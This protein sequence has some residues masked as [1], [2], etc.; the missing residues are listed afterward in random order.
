MPI[1]HVTAGLRKNNRC[2]RDIGVQIRQRRTRLGWTVQKLAT[3]A[4]IDNG[5]LSK[6]ET[7]K[8]TGSWET[9]IKLAGA[10]GVSVETLLTKKGNIEDAPLDWRRIPVLSYAQAGRWAGGDGVPNSEDVRETVMTD[11]EHPPSTFAMRILDNSMEPDFRIGDIVVIDPT[12]KARAGDFVVALEESGVGMF[13]QYR[14]PTVNDQGVIVY[15]LHPLNPIYEDL[16]SDRQRLT[17]LG[18]MV[19]HRRYRPK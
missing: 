1:M 2:M 7:G 4:E 10:L 15:E 13:L 16:R 18:V 5:F 8:A 3:L 9:Y 6:I 17:L 14:K 12:L 19:E 11:L